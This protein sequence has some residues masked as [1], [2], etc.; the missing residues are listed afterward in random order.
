MVYSAKGQ[1]ERALSTVDAGVIDAANADCDISYWL[2]SLYALEGKR[3]LALEWLRRSIALGNE[4][5]PWF[6]RDSN[7]ASMRGDG[8]Y[9]EILEQVRARTGRS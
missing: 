3:G 4:N 6:E 9:E 2:A 8:E 5:L 1:S 7:W